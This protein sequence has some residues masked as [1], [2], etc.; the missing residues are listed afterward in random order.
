MHAVK[1]NW[2]SNMRSLI[3][4][5]AFG[6]LCGCSEPKKSVPVIKPVV[7]ASGRI[8]SVPELGIEPVESITVPDAEIPNLIRLVSPFTTE[9]DVNMKLHHHVADVS[10]EHADGSM[11]TIHVRW[12]GQNPAAVSVDGSN[13]FQGGPEF[14]D[15]AM[16]TIR[17]LNSCQP[18][19]W[20]SELSSAHEK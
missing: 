10:L 11:T 4:L 1:I 6:I 2:E 12:T 18:G 17:F 14:A 19:G 8:L 9:F 15:G 7:R 16:D 13:Y 5:A 3:S 20:R